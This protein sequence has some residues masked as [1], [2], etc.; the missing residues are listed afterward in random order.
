MAAAFL[1]AAFLATAFFGA[2]FLAA[3]FF[4]AAFL[5]AAFFGAAFLAAAFL[6]AASAGA[7]AAG[8]AALRAGA[9]FAAGRFLAPAAFF[10]GSFLAAAVF[11]AGA[12]FFLVATGNSSKRCRGESKRVEALVIIYIHFDSR[13]NGREWATATA[14]RVWTRHLP[15]YTVL[16][17]RMIFD[18]GRVRI[19][20][21]S[22]LL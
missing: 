6:G 9:F 21:S 17:S 22:R 10:A 14:S 13:R 5:A 15:L 12:D 11:L 20:F 1:G 7:A 2:A 4:G 3:A 18:S 16:R 19:E 8:A